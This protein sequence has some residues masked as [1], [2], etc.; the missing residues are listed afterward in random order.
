MQAEKTTR[1]RKLTKAAAITCWLLLVLYWV[2]LRFLGE[3]WLLSGALL[4]APHVLWLLP[5]GGLLVALAVVGPR[6][7]LPVQLGAI[8]FVVFEL[9]GLVTAGPAAQTPGAPRMRVLSVNVASGRRDV[10]ALVSEIAA[11]APD[12]VLL[13]ESSEQVNRAVA[14]G[15]PGFHTATSTQ[16][17]I[18]SR[19][20]LG[21][22]FEPPK[23]ALG[24]AERSPR[25][26][27]LSV[28]S[29]LGVLDVLVVHPISPRDALEELRY[30]RLGAERAE[31]VTNTALRRRQVEAIARVASTSV[32]PVII[33]GDTN[34]PRHSRIYADLLGDWQDGFSTVGRGFGYT[35]PVGRRF[36]W[37]R[38]DRILAKPPLRFLRFGVGQRG[39][40]DHYLVWADLERALR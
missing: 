5:T 36:A 33:A 10:A 30:E 2:A 26:I 38:I 32:N 16:F 20:P 40:S 35:F 19:S 25:F 27:R 37:M 15:L 4:Y 12:L 31:I 14:A 29:P 24:A 22:L 21:E 17:F 23:L 3:A 18:A 8:A 11:L 28:R 39:G 7:L 1:L 6:Q 13:Q 9:M 34:L